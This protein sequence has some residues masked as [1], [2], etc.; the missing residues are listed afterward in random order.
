[1]SDSIRDRL[2]IV[3][4]LLPS[5]RLAEVLQFVELLLDPEPESVV[6]LEEAWMVASGAFRVVIWDD[7]HPPTVIR[8]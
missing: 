6:D 7:G 4:D 3:V 5:I 2:H 1:M 8:A